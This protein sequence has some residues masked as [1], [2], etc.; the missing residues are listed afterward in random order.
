M[1]RQ[2]FDPDIRNLKFR[3]RG[4]TV[5]INGPIMGLGLDYVGIKTLH[6]L[7]QDILESNQKLYENMIEMEEQDTS[8]CF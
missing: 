8:F 6:A 3:V 4:L 2:Q 1:K 7:T 5:E